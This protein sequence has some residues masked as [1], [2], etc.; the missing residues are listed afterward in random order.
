MKKMIISALILISLTAT[1]IASD[2]NKINAGIRNSFTSSYSDASNV[3][4]TL[5]AAFAQVDFELNGKKLS[6]YYEPSGELI[7]TSEKI[8]VDEL[9]VN[10]K[11]SFA[12][13][14]AGYTVNEAIKFTSSDEVAYY[15]STV[16][17]GKSQI[18]K[19]YDTG[20]VSVLR[21]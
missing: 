3:T 11:R 21:K 20:Y 8:S 7:G 14:Y 2:A 6:A 10:A 13:K 12:K 15:I 1:A 9:P 16:N 5:K 17:G 18:I 4:W 19:L